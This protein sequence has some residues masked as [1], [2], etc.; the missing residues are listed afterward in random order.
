MAD[1]TADRTTP[2]S[3]LSPSARTRRPAAVAPQTAGGVR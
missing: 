2:T 1:I 3:E